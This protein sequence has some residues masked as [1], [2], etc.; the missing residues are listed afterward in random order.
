M[1]VPLTHKLSADVVVDLTGLRRD[2]ETGLVT[3]LVWHCFKDG[4]YYGIV[5]VGQQPPNGDYKV[6]SAGRED[7]TKSWVSTQLDELV[8]FCNDNWSDDK[9]TQFFA[10]E[11]KITTTGDSTWEI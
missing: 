9:V 8:Q 10:P 2:H 3:C 7:P 11:G 6:L 5:S 4:K 1:P